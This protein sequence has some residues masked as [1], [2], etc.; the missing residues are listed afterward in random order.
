[1]INK[2]TAGRHCVCFSNNPECLLL[3]DVKVD[4]PFSVIYFTV[5]LTNTP[6]LLCLADIDRYR[7]YFNNVDNV[8]VHKLQEYPIVRKWG[9]L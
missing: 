9:H 2:S 7:I 6:F 3:G 1:M 5:M 4:T 8:I